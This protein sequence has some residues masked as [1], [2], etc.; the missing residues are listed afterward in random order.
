MLY[1]QPETVFH[2]QEGL[3]SPCPDIEKSNETEWTTAQIFLSCTIE[4][5]IDNIE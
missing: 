1:K 5:L 4:T 3:L 2:G